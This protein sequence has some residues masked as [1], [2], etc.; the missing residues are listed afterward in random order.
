MSPKYPN[1][2]THGLPLLL[3]PAPL[4]RFHLGSDLVFK[5]P[6]KAH[7]SQ[8]K[9]FSLSLSCLKYFFPRQYLARADSIC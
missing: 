7:E 1:S 8:N 2:R 4:I 3:T 5:C 9:A 6:P